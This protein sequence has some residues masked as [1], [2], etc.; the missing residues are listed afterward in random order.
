MKVVRLSALS[1]GRHY[2]QET[3][4]VLISVRGWVHPRAI[5]QPE[6]LCQW[7]NYLIKYSTRFGHVHSSSSGV[8][9][10]CIHAIGICH[11]SSAGCLL[12]WSGFSIL[13]TLADASRTRMTNT[14]CVYTVLRYSWWRTVD[15]SETCRVLYQINLR[16]SATRWLSLQERIW[17]FSFRL[18]LCHCPNAPGTSISLRVSKSICQSSLFDLLL[19][20]S[21]IRLQSLRGRSDQERDKW[22]F[23]VMPKDLCHFP[24][25]NAYSKSE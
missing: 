12:A 21:T 20:V 11:S 16:N 6:G 18:W 19:A 14:Y 2:S 7:K 4:L 3:F 15:M 17:R 9:Q 1:T 8:S 24:K 13:T 23:Q 25:E 5:V 22:R 10:H